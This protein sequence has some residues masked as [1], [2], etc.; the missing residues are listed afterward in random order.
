VTDVSG[1]V[2]VADSF[3]EV[4]VAANKTGGFGFSIGR[5]SIGFIG[6]LTGGSG[7]SDGS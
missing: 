6:C 5:C 2:W 4:D 3:D 7:G 1:T